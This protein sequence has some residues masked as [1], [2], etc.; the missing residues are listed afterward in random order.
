MHAVDTLV[1]SS[2]N[3]VLRNG[4]EKVCAVGWFVWLLVGWRVC[5]LAMNMRVVVA[6]G[7]IVICACCVCADG[8]SVCCLL[9]VPPHAH[10]TTPHPR[11]RFV[12]A[13]AAAHTPA[14]TTHSLL[15]RAL[16]ATQLRCCRRSGVSCWLGL[17]T[18]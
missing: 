12:A 3:N 6:V 13:A 5:L 16:A 15:P 14:S 18:S 1:A 10:C 9:F 8:A 4:Y 7:V 17:G 11:R 2:S